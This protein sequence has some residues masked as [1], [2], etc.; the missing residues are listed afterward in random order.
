MRYELMR[1]EKQIA[2]TEFGPGGQSALENS[3]I[4]IIGCGALGS[5]QAGI[6]VRMGAGRIRI[7]D[8]DHVTIGNIH[9]QMLFT[10]RHAREKRL[11][12]EAARE[13]LLRIRED[14]EI[15]ILPE[16]ITSENIEAFIKDADIVLDAVDDVQARFLA[17]DSCRKLKKPWIYT[18]VA[19]TGGMVM[20]VLPPG[21]PC[22]RCLFPVPPAKEDSANC[23]NSGILPQTVAMAVSIQ[24]NQAVKVLTGRAESGSAI[25]FDCMKPELRKIAVP[26][27]EGCVCG[28]ASG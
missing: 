8:G 17:N 24:L 27:R 1:Y 22:L 6:L 12:V 15:D 21:G 16:F 11:K 9:R 26:R 20:P 3:M 7:A 28:S 18:G 2:V 19:G 14:A 10:E 25:R 5:L 23:L 13:E 4:V